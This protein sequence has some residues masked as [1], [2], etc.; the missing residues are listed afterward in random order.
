MRLKQ[1]DYNEKSDRPG[2]VAYLVTGLEVYFTATS[3]SLSPTIADGELIVQAICEA[4]G[5]HWLDYSFH[6]IQT[7]VGYPCRLGHQIDR[8]VLDNKWRSLHI[9]DWTTLT[10]APFE[11]MTAFAIYINSDE[12]ANAA[13]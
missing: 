10:E 11:V 6:D 13:D 5:I 8:L 7:H 3:N 4:E 12:L 1:L 2:Q 9:T